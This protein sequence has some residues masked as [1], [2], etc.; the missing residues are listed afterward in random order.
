MADIIGW[1][2]V[3]ASVQLLSWGVNQSEVTSDLNALGHQFAR[4]LPEVIDNE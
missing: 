2:P 1:L 3:G 4:Y